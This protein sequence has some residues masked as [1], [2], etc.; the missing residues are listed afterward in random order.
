ME[1]SIFLFCFGLETIMPVLSKIHDLCLIN[2]PGRL[3]FTLLIYYMR[4]RKAVSQTVSLL[5]V[6]FEALLLSCKLRKIYSWLPCHIGG[7]L[8]SHLMHWKLFYC[9]FP[10][11]PRVSVSVVPNECGLYLVFAGPSSPPLGISGS[12]QF[13][14]C[15]LAWPQCLVDSG[16]SPCLKYPGEYF[17]I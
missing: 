14:L 6:A 16:A 10:F 8:L 9:H 1:K 13:S 7:V 15:Y 3:I 4:G 2:L 12:L 11:E 5:N 17:W